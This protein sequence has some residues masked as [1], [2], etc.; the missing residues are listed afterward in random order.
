M[1]VVHKSFYMCCREALENKTSKKER[2]KQQHDNTSLTDY[3]IRSNIHTYIAVTEQKQNEVFDGLLKSFIL[4]LSML[5]LQVFAATQNNTF[6]CV[7]MQYS[8]NSHP[9]VLKHKCNSENTTFKVFVCPPC[10]TWPKVI[11]SSLQL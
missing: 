10:Q 3:M 9:C 6:S 2:K 1:H 11:M 5:P 7:L 8:Q 4:K